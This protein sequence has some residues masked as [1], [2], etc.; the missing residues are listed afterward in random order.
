MGLTHNTLQSRQF[1]SK[2]LAAQLCVHIKV[3]F[4]F[5]YV[6]RVIV[7]VFLYPSTKSFSLVLLKLLSFSSYATGENYLDI[8]VTVLEYMNLATYMS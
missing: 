8:M 1:P 5:I 3:T 7:Y 2:M 4:I 6:F